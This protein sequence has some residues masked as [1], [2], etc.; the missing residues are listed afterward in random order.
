MLINKLILKEV[1]DIGT[2]KAT[3][4]RIVVKTVVILEDSIGV[5]GIVSR[6][7]LLVVATYV[8]RLKNNNQS[9]N[10]HKGSLEKLEPNDKNKD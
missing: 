4:I 9:D 1:G 3:Q 5:L 8:A 7:R 10:T 2:N 6:E